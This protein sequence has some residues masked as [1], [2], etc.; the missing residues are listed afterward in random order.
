MH[1]GQTDS[2]LLSRG[3]AEP[4]NWT[5]ESERLLDETL[6]V[7][8][9]ADI[10]HRHVPLTVTTFNHTPNKLQIYKIAIKLLKI[11]TCHFFPQIKIIA[12]QI[13]R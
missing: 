7:L 1:G 9:F 2:A 4:W 11:R 8:Q 10:L 5:V 6:S 12:I 13:H 3:A